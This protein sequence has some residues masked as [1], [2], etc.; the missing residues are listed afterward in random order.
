MRLQINMK[1][2]I[3]SIGLYCWHNFRL[4]FLAICMLSLREVEDEIGIPY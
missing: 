4:G 3:R 1:I 2:L